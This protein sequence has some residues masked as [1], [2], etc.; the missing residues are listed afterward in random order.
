MM[1]GHPPDLTLYGIAG[2]SLEQTWAR[3]MP[4]K[5][6]SQLRD[7]VTLMLDPEPAG[8]PGILWFWS[9]MNQNFIMW[10][11]LTKEGRLYAAVYG[12]VSL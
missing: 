9:V 1:V 3:K 5:F 11:Q 7:T 6:S 12:A 4:R 2:E 10:K 8:R